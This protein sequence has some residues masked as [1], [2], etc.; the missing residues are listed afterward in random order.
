[1]AR[2]ASPKTDQVRCNDLCQILG[3]VQGILLK[4]GE[5][6][7]EPESL[8]TPQENTHRINQHGLTEPH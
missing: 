2:E 7:L 1:M 6:L 8:R 5:E 4:K 3:G